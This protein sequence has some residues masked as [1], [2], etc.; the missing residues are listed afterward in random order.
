MPLPPAPPRPVLKQFPLSELERSMLLG[1]VVQGWKAAEDLGNAE[2]AE[3][4]AD[5]LGKL[6]G[7]DAKVIVLRPDSDDDPFMSLLFPGA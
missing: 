3:A 5:L 4:M 6:S 7:V 1:L 2:R